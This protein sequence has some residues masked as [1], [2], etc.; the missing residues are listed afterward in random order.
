[1]ISVQSVTSTGNKEGGIVVSV[2]R[3]IINKLHEG[4]SKKLKEAKIPT[5]NELHAICRKYGYDF[6]FTDRVGKYVRLYNL[7]GKDKYSPDVYYSSSF[8]KAPT[9]EISQS[10]YGSMGVLEFEKL[11]KCNLDAI[12]MVKELSKLDINSM[13][14]QMD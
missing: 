13:N 12:N 5:E 7:R 10:S 11:T 3:E 6:D 8:G 4:K 2:E 1:M 9:F 14:V